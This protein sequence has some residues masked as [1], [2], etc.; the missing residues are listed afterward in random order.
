M[1]SI[2]QTLPPGNS[3]LR[4]HFQRAI[5]L[6]GTE[7]SGKPRHAASDISA[8]DTTQ[9]Q[10]IRD[11]EKKKPFRMSEMPLVPLKPALQAAQ[12]KIT[13][14]ILVN[15]YAWLWLNRQGDP[16]SVCQEVYRNQLG[17]NSTVAQRRELWAR[18]LAAKTEFWR[19][20]RQCAGVLHF[21]SLGYNRRG[22]V[23]QPEGGATSDH[24]LNV[25]RLTWQPYFEDFVRDAF[26]PVGV[27]LDFWAEEIQSGSQQA[28]AVA[29]I[30]DLDHD[31]QG[32]VRLRLV[33][34]G[35]TRW[36][37]TRSLTVPALGRE[38]V[39]FPSSFAVPAGP[40]ELIAELDSPGNKPVKSRRT[41]Q[42][43]ETPI[44]RGP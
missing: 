44:R 39:R 18:Y 2:E 13:V 42:V 21:C 28:I 6:P 22:D 3:S 24:W 14:P 31:W 23:P 5:S 15:E 9:T 36:N 8:G 41:L 12:Q 1:E 25:K 19:S 35:Q 29:V 43:R 10:F 33:Q 4:R 40:S 7:N 11:W 17:A 30:N 27:M 26:N 38:T 16:T 34:R 20:H 32:N 37:Q